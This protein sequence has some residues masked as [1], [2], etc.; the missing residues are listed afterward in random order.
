V[1]EPVAAAGAGLGAGCF[2]AWPR[3]GD[4]AGAQNAALRK[5][6]RKVRDMRAFRRERG[7]DLQYHFAR[8][9]ARRAAAAPA[10]LVPA[11]LRGRACFSCDR[12]RARASPGM[13]LRP[14]ALVLLLGLT[15]GCGSDAPFTADLKMICAAGKGRDDLPPSMRSLEAAKEI[16]DNIKTP[17]AARLMVQLMQAAPSE[18][19][20]LL[21]QPLAKAGIK[22]CA[23]FER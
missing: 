2:G 13:L 18:R 1:I 5:K 15:G 10:A 4:D 9:A 6:A 16:A 20:E 7:V 23:L 3:A 8:L 12:G 19:A 11:G 22:R 21:R 14:I 17:E